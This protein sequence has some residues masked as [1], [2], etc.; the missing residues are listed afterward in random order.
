MC[1]AA[2]LNTESR[3]WAGFDHNTDHSPVKSYSPTQQR[4]Q[5]LNPL[6]KQE[7]LFHADYLK[8]M[9]FI[10]KANSVDE[11]LAN[12]IKEKKGWGDK[13]VCNTWKK[14]RDT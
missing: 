13:V 1:L 12:L 4:L 8:L 14:R 6:D 7:I 3:K 2:T 11:N 10:L 5:T 9:L